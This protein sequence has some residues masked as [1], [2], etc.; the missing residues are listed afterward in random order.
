MGYANNSAEDGQPRP[1]SG[2]S[3]S[4]GSTLA[5]P[6]KIGPARKKKIA[7]YSPFRQP[8]G[9]GPDGKPSAGPKL[10]ERENPPCCL[11]AAQHSELLAIIDSISGPGA[12][13]RGPD[14]PS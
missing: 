8:G 11:F 4:A 3:R 9:P 2:W 13:P 6:A 1:C 5:D 14:Q 7:T 10:G 12:N